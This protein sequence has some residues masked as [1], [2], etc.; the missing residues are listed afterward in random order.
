MLTEV[1][2]SVK[3]LV[4]VFLE[5]SGADGDGTTLSK[6]EFKQ[7]MLK[8]LPGYLENQKDSSVTDRLMA[9][10]DGD[11]D[12]HLSFLEFSRMIAGLTISC[13]KWCQQRPPS[14]S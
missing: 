10:L 11:G 7:L 6:S 4:S 5:Y 13:D 1:E 14:K 8:E 2:R 12:G 3:T 9:D